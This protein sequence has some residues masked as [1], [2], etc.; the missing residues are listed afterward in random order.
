MVAY[1]PPTKELDLA[2][3][4]RMYPELEMVNEDEQIR[5][6]D[7]EYKKKRGKG[8]P[9]KAASKGM[10]IVHICGIH[11]LTCFQTRHADR[12]RSGNIPANK[13]ALYISLFSFLS[14]KCHEHP[15]ISI[16]IAFGRV[17]GPTTCPPNPPR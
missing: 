15:S 8:A 10:Y 1:Y 16:S 14:A 6:E 2:R 13:L 3:I 7:V 11:L 12:A 5:L 17:S 4:V 9:K